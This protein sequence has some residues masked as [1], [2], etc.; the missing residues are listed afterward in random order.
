MPHEIQLINR[1]ET[2]ADRMNDA[3]KIHELCDMQT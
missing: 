1:W 2:T 3:P